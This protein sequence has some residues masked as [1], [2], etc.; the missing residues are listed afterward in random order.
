MA[1][2]TN[3]PVQTIPFQGSIAE[4]AFTAGDAA[5][6]MQFDNDGNTLLLIQTTT[7][8]TVTTVVSVDDEF[9]RDG[10]DV[11]TTGTNKIGTGGP[12]IQSIWNQ[13]GRIC[14]VDLDQD[15]GMSIAAVKYSPRK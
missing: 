8:A 3:I 13:A 14:F 12:Y 7:N 9:S 4:V 5:N 10:D 1:A 15:T 6:G 11:I 2:R